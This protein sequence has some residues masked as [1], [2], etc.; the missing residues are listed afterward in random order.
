MDSFIDMLKKRED[1]LEELIYRCKKQLSVLPK[2]TLRVA[3]KRYGPQYYAKS[4]GKKEVYLTK[5]QK[6][7]AE[8]LAQSD[9]CD[10]VLRQA[11]REQRL[12]RMAMKACR[13]NSIEAIWTGM[14]P[15]R[16]A[17]VEPFVLTDEEYVARWSSQTYTPRKFNENDIS[18]T[19]ERGERVRSK[20]EKIIADM[21]LVRGVPYYY[22]F[23][24]DMPGW[25]VIYPDFR[26]LNVRTRREYRLE[27]FGMMDNPDYAAGF[28]RK[29]KMYEQNGYFPGDNLL[30]T[31]ETSR[32]PLRPEVVSE[33]IQ[34]F[35]K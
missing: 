11:T 8:R 31:M 35:L 32:E 27:H 25:G 10:K 5:K 22:E 18:Y 13:E 24:L 29:M 9:Y 6:G 33:L 15:A 2:G 20:S 7:L 19:T 4:D 14:H 30:F 23:P 1:E 17:L 12:V 21:L 28:L 26:V 16:R 3:A 34:R